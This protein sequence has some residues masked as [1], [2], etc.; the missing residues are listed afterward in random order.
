METV[1]LGLVLILVLGLGLWFGLGGMSREK[2]PALVISSAV[3]KLPTVIT[4]VDGSHVGM[5]FGGVDVFVCLSVCLSV[6]M[7]FH[8]TYRIM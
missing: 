5:V 1:W 7:F 4:H 2:C 6:C 8:T 3:Y